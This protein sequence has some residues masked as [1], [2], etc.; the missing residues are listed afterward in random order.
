[1]MTRAAA[2]SNKMRCL[3]DA[4]APRPTHVEKEDDKWDNEK[5]LPSVGLERRQKDVGSGTKKRTKTTA[6]AWQAAI[7]IN[8][9]R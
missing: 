9:A 4:E 2:V 1:M 8:T 3:V 6:E 7:L 5:R